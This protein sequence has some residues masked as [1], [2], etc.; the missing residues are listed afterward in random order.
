MVSHGLRST[1]TNQIAFDQRDSKAISQFER[2]M[3]PCCQALVSRFFLVFK[4][5]T[6][7][8]ISFNHGLF[9]NG[10]ETRSRDVWKPVS[11]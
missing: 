11:N 8:I 6:L 10:W 4:L 9:T 7:D 1:V 2:T 3:D 5:V